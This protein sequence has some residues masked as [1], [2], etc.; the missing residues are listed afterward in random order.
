MNNM[1]LSKRV[2]IYVLLAVLVCVVSVSAFAYAMQRGEII[3]ESANRALAIAR[4]V[5]AALDPEQY[6]AIMASGETSEYYDDYKA[7]IGDALVKNEA[8]YLYVLDAEYGAE[9]TY[10]AEGYVSGVSPDEEYL[11]GDTEAADVFSEEMYETLSTGQDSST[12]VYNLGGFGDMISGF[13]PIVS[14][15]GRVLGVVGVDILID[16]AMATAGRTGLYMLAVA[17]G[18]CAIVMCAALVTIRK[19]FAP[20]TH[21]SSAMNQIGSAGNLAFSAEV[22]N[23]ARRTSAW[24]NEIGVCAKAFESTL[25]RL[26]YIESTLKEITGG[27]LSLDVEVLS[28]RDEIGGAISSLVAQ[29]NAVFADMLSGSERVSTSAER[30]AG[31]AKELAGGAA[32]QGE[33]IG[34]LS[35]SMSE[36][37]EKTK[38]N[39]MKAEQAAALADTI[40]G[41]AEKGG[42]QMDDVMRSVSDINESSQAISKVIKTI[43]DIAFQTNILALNAAVEAARAGHH[44]KG[45]AVVAEE[46]RNLATKSA[47]AAKD[48]E[49]LIEDSRAKAELGARISAE[50]SESL[51]QIVRGIN[52]SGALIR[53]IAGATEGQTDDISKINTGID[54]VAKIVEQNTAAAKESASASEEMSAQAELLLRAVSRF[55]L[56]EGGEAE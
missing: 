52:E 45:F 40:R 48:T 15:S 31:G 12:G 49:S 30:V 3:K 4:T 20:L 37:T 18:A 54:Q 35:G 19:T 21:L 22:M 27:N 29:L 36:I 9:V 46:V 5:G 42:R 24:K 38:A 17:L 1:S 51:E 13:S 26:R 28:E 33:S 10:F 44:G 55:R 39:A 34:A 8:I 23:S 32:L 16:E 11:F 14:D 41:N 53:E 43:D 25:R 56:H 50:M 6:A 47:E 7:F 2:A